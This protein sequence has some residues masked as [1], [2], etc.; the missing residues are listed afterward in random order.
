MSPAYGLDGGIADM[1]NNPYPRAIRSSD[2]APIAV[3][4]ALAWESAAVRAALRQVKREEERVWRGSINKRE[5]VVITGG[6]G[7]RRTQ[8]TLEHFAQHP[9]AAFLSVGCA[10]A[11]VSGLTTGQLILAP[12]V[13]MW[14]PQVEAQLD[15]FRMDA[16]LF[17]HACTAAS[18]AMIPHA[19]GSLFT[20]AKV[21]HT[22]E[23]KAEQ[24]RV[25]GA[26]AVEM[27]SAV[28]AAF[29]AA[30]SL[31]FLV[32]RVILDPAGM[33]IPVV[34]GL[35]TPEG[36]VRPLKAVTHM[37]THPQHLSPLLEL[38][39]ARA[40]TAQAITRLCRALFPLLEKE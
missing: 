25:T 24:G 27:E 19:E 33:A 15:R 38:K 31:P 28:H 1:N 14:S 37:L 17:N 16:K 36:K 20:S 8:Q 29:A 21:L 4:T 3:F 5:V 6:I 11:L 2:S 35:M 39:R 9:F 12:E 23:D 7:P 22:P 26:I 13:C 30:R 32:L 18:L 34:K 10:G 40:T